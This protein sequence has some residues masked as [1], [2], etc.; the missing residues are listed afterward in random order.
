MSEDSLAQRVL[1]F[2]HAK[3]FI[4]QSRTDFS[5]FRSAC[6]NGSAVLYVFLS[7]EVPMH[8]LRAVYTLQLPL[9]LPERVRVWVSSVLNNK[10]MEIDLAKSE[11][12]VLRPLFT[13]DAAALAISIDHWG[14]CSLLF[15]RHFDGK[16]CVSA[17]QSMRDAVTIHFQVSIGKSSGLME[18]SSQKSKRRCVRCVPNSCEWGE[19]TYSLFTITIRL[20]PAAFRHISSAHRTSSIEPNASDNA[21]ERTAIDRAFR[22]R[23]CASSMCG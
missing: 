17:F 5:S 9:R 12:P 11:L 6:D 23:V 7:Q 18:G 1:H 2:I 16:R 20:F 13:A 4:L 10:W 19:L 22:A 21:N 14:T 8:P 3:K 15:C